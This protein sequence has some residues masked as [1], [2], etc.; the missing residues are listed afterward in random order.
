[1]VSEERQKKY[2]QRIKEFRLMDDDFMTACFSESIECTELVLQIMLGDQNLK[3]LEV[4]TQHSIKNLQGRSVR[5]DVYAVGADGQRMNIEIQRQEKGAGFKRAR[6]SS[7]LI[8]AAILPSG[9]DTD[10]L[11]DTYVIFITESD[12][13]GK[14]LAVYHIDKY[15]TETGELFD[16]G[17]HILYVNG[18]YRDDSPIGKL[19]YDFS[20]AEPDQMVY[21]ELAKRVRYF[22]EEPEGVNIMCRAMEELCNEAKM[23]GVQEGIQK[24]IQQGSRKAALNMLASKKLSLETIAMYSGL[25][26]EEVKELEKQI[27]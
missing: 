20:C 15:I 11:P 2:L 4:H 23:E 7:S 22:K 26:L 25:K 18:A 9:E 24:G 17:S 13:I 6:Y 12:V 19:M 1:M 10:N 21:K 5:L 16:D 8:D 14:G 3:V 27:S